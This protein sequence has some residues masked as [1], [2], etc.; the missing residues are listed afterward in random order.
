MSSVETTTA[1]EPGLFCSS[2]EAR[3]ME[4]SEAEQPWPLRLYV[5]QLE[6]M[7]NLLCAIAQSDGV[8]EK[9]EQLTTKKSTSFGFTPVT[10]K[11]CSRHEVMTVSASLRMAA[12]DS[13][14]WMPLSRQRPMAGGH[15]VFCPVP[16]LASTFSMKAMSSFVKVPFS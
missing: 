15:A 16:E 4:S 9:S 3:S 14:W 12:I 6:R 11:S 1:M 10:A 13:S 5:R 2:S 7:L 8:G